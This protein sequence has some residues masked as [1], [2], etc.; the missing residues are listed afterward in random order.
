MTLSQKMFS[1]SETQCDL[2][3]SC[4]EESGRKKSRPLF[5]RDWEVFVIKR[6]EQT[7]KHIW[8]TLCCEA[9]NTDG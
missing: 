3:I 9:A 8:F 4:R 2:L 6:D 1:R 5:E 7:G